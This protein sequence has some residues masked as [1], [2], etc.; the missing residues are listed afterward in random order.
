MDTSKLYDLLVKLVFHLHSVCPP[1]ALA[2][3]RD[4]FQVRR[5][6]E[7]RNDRKR[8]KEK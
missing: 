3:H 1:D 2:G 4:R 8:E 5:L 6:R 7:E